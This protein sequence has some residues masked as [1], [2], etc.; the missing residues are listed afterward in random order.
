MFQFISKRENEMK[1]GCSKAADRIKMKQKRFET[2]DMETA[3]IF[4][5]V[6]SSGDRQTT[7]R[8]ILD[9]T[10]YADRNGIR[11]EQIYEEHISGAKKNYERP[12][13]QEC[14]AYCLENTVSILLVSELS[15]LGRNVDEVLANIRFAK[16]NHLNIY[17]Q[18]EG[19]SIY[20]SDG[21]ENP[22]LTI[23]IA[24]LGTAAQME[25]ESIHYRL[26]SGRKVYV[27]KNMKETG[28]S[29]LGRRVGYKKPTADYE[30]EYK[31]VIKLLRK[32]Y[33]I[34]TISSLTGRSLATIQKVKNIF[35]SN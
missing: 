1:I 17:F 9:L 7:E 24:V 12:V 23:M 6:S 16:E 32:G 31:D 10:D 5:R 29:G 11:V 13:L 25:R 20:G 34:R 14:L 15:R 21:K 28:K 8:Q 2:K 30:N 19:I 3:V 27:D 22:Y 4:A 35:A 26:Q 18:K 33:P